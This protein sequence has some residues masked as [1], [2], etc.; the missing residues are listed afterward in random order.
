[1]W[2]RHS[3]MLALLTDLVG[4]WGE[5]KNPRMNKTKKAYGFN[6]LLANCPAKCSEIFLFSCQFLSRRT[7][8]QLIIKKNRLNVNFCSPEIICVRSFFLAISLVM[9][10]FFAYHLKNQWNHLKSQWLDWL[11]KHLSHGQNQQVLAVWQWQQWRCSS[12][13]LG[14]RGRPFGGQC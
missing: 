2:A 9:C 13:S 10:R 12:S 3:E 5:T 14:S 1:M 8:E 11:K 7:H 6:V 4:E